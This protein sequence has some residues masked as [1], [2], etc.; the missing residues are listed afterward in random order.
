[1]RYLHATPW[2]SNWSIMWLKFAYSFHSYKFH[3]LCLCTSYW[4]LSLPMVNSFGAYIYYSQSSSF[5]FI[6]T[7]FRH[8]NLLLLHKFLAFLACVLLLFLTLV[9]LLFA[10]IFH[11]MC[12]F[13]TPNICIVV[14]HKSPYYWCW[15]WN[16]NKLC[17]WLTTIYQ[18]VICVS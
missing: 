8:V 13:L 1:M 6:S 17:W 4:S 15:V 5:V 12:T 9:L 14:G 3:D 11:C 18:I 10:F 16:M 7:Y 2:Y